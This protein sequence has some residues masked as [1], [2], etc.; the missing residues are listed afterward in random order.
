MQWVSVCKV[1]SLGDHSDGSSPRAGPRLPLCM[2][3]ALRILPLCHICKCVIQSSWL[4]RFSH[5]DFFTGQH[6]PPPITEHTWICNGFGVLATVDPK[7]IVRE[8]MEGYQSSRRKQWG[9]STQSC[10]EETRPGQGDS[11]LPPESLHSPALTPRRITRAYTSVTHS[12]G[13]GIR[14]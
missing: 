13:G 10:G 7:A 8:K 3:R 1:D 11:W 5:V 14:P 2:D 12:G 4:F 6:W 9:T